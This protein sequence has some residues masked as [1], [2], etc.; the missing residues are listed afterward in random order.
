MKTKSRTIRVR[1]QAFVY[2]HTSGVQF[3]LYLSPKEQ[4]NT[5]LM[6]VFPAIPPDEDPHTSWT[7]YEI[8]AQK[9]GEPANLHLGR[10][11]SIA[12][13]IAYVQR[14]QPELW[15]TGHTIRVENAWTLLE[16][17]GYVECKPVWK[18]EF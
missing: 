6:L 9:D 2:W 4:K 12:E 14:R 15:Q 8:S 3:T 7:F 10:P 1:D 13:I 16:E 5:K 18:G 17:V 11:R